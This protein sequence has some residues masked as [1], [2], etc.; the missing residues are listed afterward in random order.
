[1]N[2]DEVIQVRVTTEQ[3]AA[4]VKLSVHFDRS[5]SAIARYAIDLMI[6]GWVPFTA[7]EAQ[8]VIRLEAAI[9]EGANDGE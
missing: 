9:E 5:L 2:K 1:M 7:D 4:I 8:E 6:G 3:Y